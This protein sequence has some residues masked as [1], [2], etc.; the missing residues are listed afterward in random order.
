MYPD[1]PFEETYD[2]SHSR[3]VKRYDSYD[4]VILYPSRNTILDGIFFLPVK[5]KIAWT[6][7]I[8]KDH[9]LEG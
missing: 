1:T 9:F 6:A 4:H 5:M 2:N 3:K 7:T 8:V